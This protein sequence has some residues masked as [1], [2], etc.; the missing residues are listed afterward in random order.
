MTLTVTV[1][2][3]FL[4]LTITPSIGPSSAE[5]TRPVSA[6]ALCAAAGEV[7]L[8]RPRVNANAVP[9]TTARRRTCIAASLNLSLAI[10][11]GAGQS[12]AWAGLA[13]S[14]EPARG[15]FN[16][17]SPGARTCHASARDIAIHHP[18]AAR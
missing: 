18:D 5:A 10:A 1:E 4:A 15:Q 12:R 2:P 17:A 6:A 13:A 3:S 8:E 14:V 11:S 7:T 16:A 9:A